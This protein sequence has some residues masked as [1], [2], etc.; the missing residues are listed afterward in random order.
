MNLSTKQKDSQTERT[1]LWLPRGRGKGVA[2]TG[3]L[4]LVVQTITFRLDGQRGPT[5]SNLLGTVSSVLG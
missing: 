4:G 1:D 3:S 2:W 5:V